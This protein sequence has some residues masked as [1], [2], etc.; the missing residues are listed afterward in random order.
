MGKFEYLSVLVSI[1]I[2]LALANLLSGAARLIQLRARVQPH[3]PTLCWMATLFLIN[4]QVWWAAFDRRHSGDWSF[5]AFL[6]FLLIPIILS[7]LSYLVLPDLGDEDA[8]DLAANFN[9]NRPWFFGLLAA[10]P[11]ISLIDQ[12]LRDGRMPADLDALFRV[13][14]AGLSLLAARVRSERFHVANALVALALFLG[15]IGVLFL[16]LR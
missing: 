3:V 11:V 15:Y 7:L 4:V 16:R 13:V 12:W 10:A 6:L 8:V 9:H 5:F 2:G 1:I 14:F